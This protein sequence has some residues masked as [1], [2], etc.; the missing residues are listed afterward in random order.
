MSTVESHGVGPAPARALFIA[1]SLTII[2][3]YI[4]IV[5]MYL[6]RTLWALFL[7]TFIQP[8]KQRNVSDNFYIAPWFAMETCLF[9]GKK[10]AHEIFRTQFKNITV[11]SISHTNIPNIELY[12]QKGVFL[13]WYLLLK[14]NIF[15]CH[16][17][18]CY[19]TEYFYLVNY[20]NHLNNFNRDFV[21]RHPST[22]AALSMTK[23][24]RTFWSAV[25]LE[26]IIL[27]CNYF[28]RYIY[29]FDYH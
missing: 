21:R 18:R 10:D 28:C 26:N 11:I 5:T 16:R 2:I 1:H 29:L 23:W 22:Y 7:C 8:V 4:V 20:R 15:R 19:N 12:A 13:Q 17:C 6:K 25:F 24:K 9:W 27:K 14:N 3:S